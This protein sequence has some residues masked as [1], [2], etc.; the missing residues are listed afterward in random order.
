VATG[1][2]VTQQRRRVKLAAHLMSA[3]AI[4]QFEW[5]AMD[6][7]TPTRDLI[8]PGLLTRLQRICRTREINRATLGHILVAEAQRARSED[9]FYLEWLTREIELT[10]TSFA[11]GVVRYVRQQ[12]DLLQREHA[13]S[14]VYLC[15]ANTQIAADRAKLILLL[16]G[17]SQGS[18]LPLMPP[19]ISGNAEYL[20]G[21]QMKAIGR[22][23]ELAD[24][25]YAKEFLGPVR[26]RLFPLLGGASGVGKTF[27]VKKAAALLKA[28]FLSVT[29]GDWIPMGANQEFEATAFTILAK[30]ACHERVV[31]CIDEIDK[32]RLDTDS[33]W[34]RSVASDLWR[35]L[36]HSLPVAAYL[37]SPRSSLHGVDLSED[38]LAKRIPAVLWFVGAGTWQTHYEQKSGIGFSQGAKKIEQLEGRLIQ[39][40]NTIP[41][42]LLLRF[43]PEVIELAHPTPEESVEVFRSSG[44]TEAAVNVG[45]R[46]DPVTHEWRGGMRS[47][48]AIWA[49]IAI[50]RRKQHTSIFNE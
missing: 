2:T 42:E 48:E 17:L 28:E 5:E 41:S 23:L 30:V 36:D 13:M 26:P 8:R 20:T 38:K 6:E 39:R 33:A 10:L 29:A 7:T 4:L 18:S 34:G 46:L 27:L 22:L 14:L 11:N 15:I 49:E 12:R 37:R 3:A 32:V 21:R 25:F 24:A 47:L 1:E 31:V 45:L 43:H 50:L 9:I 44:L 35:A 40:T 16:S 19:P